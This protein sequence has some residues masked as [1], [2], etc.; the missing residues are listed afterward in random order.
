MFSGFGKPA[1][2]VSGSHKQ[3]GTGTD[4]KA[5]SGGFWGAFDIP[6]VFGMTGAQTTSPPRPSRVPEPAQG[7][8]ISGGR[9]TDP[10]LGYKGLG[11]GQGAPKRVSIDDRM[12]RYIEAAASMSE[13]NAPQC[14]SILRAFKPVFSVF[15]HV[16][17]LVF[18]GYARIYGRIYELYEGLPLN[19]LQMVLGLLL[20]FFGGTYVALIAAIEAFRT[21]GAQTLC[22]HVSYVMAQAR[23]ATQASR[24][25]DLL[26]ENRDGIADVDQ[27]SPEEL[28]QRKLR[29]CMLAIREPERLRS[30]IGSLWSA[31]LAVL[32]TLKLQFAQTAAYAMAIADMVKFP[33]LRAVAPSLSW[34]LG[35]ELTHWVD[36]IVDGAVKVSCI[37]LMWYLEK[38]RA[39]FYSGIRGGKMFAEALLDWSQRRGWMDKVPDSIVKKPFIASESYLDEV[40]GYTVAA[41]GFYW[42]VS[43]LFF[44]PFPI[45]WLLWPVSLAESSLEVQISWS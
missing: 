34:G 5:D 20:C 43:N 35:T 45:N 39:A 37:L 12:A 40:I 26:D 23:I 27:I 44:L 38:L 31:C 29:V 18:T 6:A 41:I 13:K 28:T 9:W 36:P 3:P 25:D 14:A 22:D 2:D 30:A 11:I 19:E 24:R 42:Q 10:L 1:E 17:I 21:M 15:L 7:G 33:V 8:L 16:G 4:A 32:A